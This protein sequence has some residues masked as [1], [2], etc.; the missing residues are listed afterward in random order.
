MV[1]IIYFYYNNSKTNINNIYTIKIVIS[2]IYI[3]QLSK[4]L[5]AIS[6][7]YLQ[8]NGNHC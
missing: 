5:Q 4:I 3:S 6:N 2:K 1:V 7:L 8:F